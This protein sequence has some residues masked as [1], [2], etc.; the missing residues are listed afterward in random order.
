MQNILHRPLIRLT[1]ISDLAKVPIDRLRGLCEQQSP[2]PIPVQSHKLYGELL[3]PSA[4]QM[5]LQRVHAASLSARPDLPSRFDRISLLLWLCSLDAKLKRKPRPAYSKKLEEEIKRIARL[6]EPHRT[7]RG[8]ELLA[9]YAD[10]RVIAD[11]L[12]NARLPTH[13]E[14]IERKLNELTGFGDISGLSSQP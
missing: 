4:T 10:A 13:I 9:R 6:P 11:T 1:E 7:M 3:S 8:L 14:R 5:L 2:I 12:V